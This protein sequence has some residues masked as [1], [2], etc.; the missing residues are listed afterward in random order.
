MPS[1]KHA[2]VVR[3]P[4]AMQIPESDEVRNRVCAESDTPCAVG[5]VNPDCALHATQ[6]ADAVV[7]GDVRVSWMGTVGETERLL[8][9]V[10]ANRSCA[11]DDCCEQARVSAVRDC[12]AHDMLNH[13]R[14]LNG[15][16]WSR[17]DVQRLTAAE[18]NV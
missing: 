4:P 18:F 9:A 16:L 7:L 3:W 6:D 15:L 1:G 8:A 13:Q 2:L 17:R 5:W 10:H 11:A 14:V 12:P